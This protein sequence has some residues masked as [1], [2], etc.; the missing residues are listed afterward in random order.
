MGWRKGKKV[1]RG[2]RE[3][4]QNEEG[5]K[6]E[7][8]EGDGRRDSCHGDTIYTL[9]RRGVEVRRNREGRVCGMLGE[10]R[11]SLPRWNHS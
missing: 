3:R 2:E 10:T 5:R 6:K 4:E 9:F 8:G 1:G 11:T 7:L